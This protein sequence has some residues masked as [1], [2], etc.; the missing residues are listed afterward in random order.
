MKLRSIYEKRGSLGNSCQLNLQNFEGNVFQ[1]VEREVKVALRL[2]KSSF[3]IQENRTMLYYLKWEKLIGVQV[4]P[5]D[6]VW[7]M[8]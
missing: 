1:R 2:S 3:T 8:S 5:E 4:R 6:G 7:A